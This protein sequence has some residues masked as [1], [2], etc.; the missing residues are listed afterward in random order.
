M[1]A[2]LKGAHAFAGAGHLNLHSEG[3]MCC[4]AN[5]ICT[6]STQASA[7]SACR[8]EACLLHRSSARHNVAMRSW[9]A[10]ACVRYRSL[11]SAISR[12][13]KS[14][15]L[16]TGTKAPPPAAGPA[17]AAQPTQHSIGPLW[18]RPWRARRAKVVPEAAIP[19]QDQ[20]GRW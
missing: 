13:K 16:C 11:R 1:A 17:P 9:K 12:P 3:T 15:P 2:T 4:I 5:N 19:A 8:K 20:K 7:S 6:S 14:T 18:G 10:L